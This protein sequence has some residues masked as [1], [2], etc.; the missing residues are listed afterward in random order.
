VIV[1]GVELY[2]LAAAA[3]VVVLEGKPAPTVSLYPP[4]AFEVAE[5][6]MGLPLIV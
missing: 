2:A 6:S 5:P 1:T 4:L 3:G